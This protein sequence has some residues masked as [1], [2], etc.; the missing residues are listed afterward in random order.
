M[1]VTS[2]SAGPDGTSPGDEKLFALVKDGDRA[3]FDRLTRRHLPAVLGLAQWITGDP[4]HADSIAADV[5]LQ[6]WT[7]CRRDRQAGL[8]FALWLDRLV[9]QRCVDSGGGAAVAGNPADTPKPAA[10]LIP[11]R[12][13][14]A[15]GLYV[16]R[17]LCC[18]EIALV[19]GLSVPMV[20]HLLIT[21]RRTYRAVVGSSAIQSPANLVVKM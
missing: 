16:Q 5:F 19:L 1:T 9:V 7:E 20:E 11:E 14:V 18:D 15:L 2:S 8:L 4:D 17:R 3:A 21:G 12:E 6:V 13:R 10:V